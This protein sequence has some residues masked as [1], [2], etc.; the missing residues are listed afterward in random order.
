MQSAKDIRRLT[1]QYSDEPSG[2]VVAV[3]KCAAGLVTLLF[4]AAGPWIVLTTDG[5]RVPAYVSQ[6]AAASA[7]SMA[8]SRRVFEERRQ[9]AQGAQETAKA[10]LN[11][12]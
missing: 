8:E 11:R 5:A 7:S 6:P 1:A 12:D 10:A 4:M 2:P 3:L 9:Q